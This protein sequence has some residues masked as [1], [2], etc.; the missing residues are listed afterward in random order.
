[1]LHSNQPLLCSRDNDLKVP[2][3]QYAAK[4]ILQTAKT[5]AKGREICAPTLQGS[6]VVPA[7]TSTNNAEKLSQCDLVTNDVSKGI[8]D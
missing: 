8:S 3:R 6:G 7:T 1:M 4:V 2:S 5:A